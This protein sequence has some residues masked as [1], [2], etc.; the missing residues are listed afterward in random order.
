MCA[1]VGLN[2]RGRY[3]GHGARC[4]LH[5]TGGAVVAQLSYSVVECAVLCVYVCIHI[6]YML[7]TIPH[8]VL[9]P[10]CSFGSASSSNSSSSRRK[11]GCEVH[12]WR[13]GKLVREGEVSR[14]RVRI[15]VYKRCERWNSETYGLRDVRKE[16]GCSP[17]RGRGRRTFLTWVCRPAKVLMPLSVASLICSCPSFEFFLLFLLCENST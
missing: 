12:Q 17:M 16:R 11:E 9:V 15:H 1:R 10:Y 2:L 8:S 3:C 7:C 14:K 5:K 6:I 4:L 13:N